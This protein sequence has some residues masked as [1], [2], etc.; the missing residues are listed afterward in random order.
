MELE[1]L[2]VLDSLVTQHL[3]Q[4]EGE[5]LHTWQ[6]CVWVRVTIMMLI[7]EQLGTLF[8]HVVPSINFTSLI[9]VEQ[10]ERCSRK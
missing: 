1:N 2:I 10:V 7:P 3:R 6:V 8:H 4:R 5:Y 9:F